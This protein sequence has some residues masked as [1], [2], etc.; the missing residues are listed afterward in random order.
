[1]GNSGISVK[2]AVAFDSPVPV[3]IGGGLRVAVTKMTPVIWRL[4]VAVPLEGKLVP[5]PGN[6]MALNS[7]VMGTAVGRGPMD[8]LRKGGN[9]NTGSGNVTLMAVV[10]G[11][12]GRIEKSAL[13]DGVVVASGDASDVTSISVLSEGVTTVSLGV[14]V[15]ETDGSDGDSSSS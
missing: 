12:K 13:G 11:P 4:T 5:A 1:M 6:G 8:E 15:M 14:G 3:P 10:I 2:A 9:E 7:S